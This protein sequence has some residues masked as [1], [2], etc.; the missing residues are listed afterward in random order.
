MLAVVL[1]IVLLN[2]SDVGLCCCYKN[3]FITWTIIVT[4]LGVNNILVIIISTHIEIVIIV[5][6]GVVVRN[7]GIIGIMISVNMIY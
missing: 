1:L 7:V 5:V 3:V 4:S 6:I 2:Y